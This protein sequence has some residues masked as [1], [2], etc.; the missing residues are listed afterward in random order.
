[1]FDE[2]PIE[3][4]YHI[5]ELAAQLAQTDAHAWVA[6]SLALVSREVHKLIIPTIYHAVL[7]DSR[8]DTMLS[9]DAFKPPPHARHTRCLMLR[10]SSSADGSLYPQLLT[11]FPAVDTFAVDYN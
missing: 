8:R 7:L 2:L 4:V 9:V 6:T 10:G 1:M 3:L 11:F 5:L